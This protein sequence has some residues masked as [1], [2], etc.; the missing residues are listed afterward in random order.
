MRK[1]WLA[2]AIA[3]TAVGVNA[4]A[5]QS[6]DPMYQL[7][8][9]TIEEVPALNLMDNPTEIPSGVGSGTCKPSLNDISKGIDEADIILD[10][11]IN[12]GK[13]IW[14]IVVKGQA[15][16]NIKVDV[17]TALPQGVNCWNTLSQWS[18]PQGKAYRVTYKNKLGMEAVRFQYQVQWLPGGTVNGQG[19]YVGYAAIIP[20]DVYG[21]WG[22]KLNARSTVPA[23]FNTGTDKSPVGALQM[24]MNWRV[25]GPFQKYEQA[26]SYY[27]DGTGKFEIVGV[28]EIEDI[29]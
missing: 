9:P 3:V 29:K 19:K 23:V 12:M 26:I 8:A 15:V 13:K 27:V 5:F 21:L 16:L 18:R 1:M 11:I 24:T 14:D 25:E 2:L 22:F 17:A 28:D 10:K 6:N 4:S 7:E 20:T